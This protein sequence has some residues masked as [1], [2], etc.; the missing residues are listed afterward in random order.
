MSLNHLS[1]DAVAGPAL[2]E[3][4]DNTASGN[5]STVGIGSASP[6]QQMLTVQNLGD[7]GVVINWNT[8]NLDVAPGQSR[9]MTFV[10]DSNNRNIDWAFTG[11]GSDCRFAWVIRRSQ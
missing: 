10:I 8:T 4:S 3:S 7:C 6:G 1:Q 9:S 5:L 11:G 2:V